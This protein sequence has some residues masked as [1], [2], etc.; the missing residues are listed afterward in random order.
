MSTKAVKRGLVNGSRGVVVSF[1]NGL[2]IVKFNCE[3][4]SL[5]YAKGRLIKTEKERSTT[6]WYVCHSC[7]TV[8]F[9]LKS[10]ISCIYLNGFFYIHIYDVFE[11]NFSVLLINKSSRWILVAQ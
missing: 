4:E 11:Y 9:I 2:P 3:H 8:A 10:T 6:R 5:E 7:E 1:K